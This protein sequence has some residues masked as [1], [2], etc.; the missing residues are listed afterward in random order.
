MA[1]IVSDEENEFVVPKLQEMV[2]LPD[3]TD[4]LTLSEQN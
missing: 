4:G 1:D 2:K 3:S